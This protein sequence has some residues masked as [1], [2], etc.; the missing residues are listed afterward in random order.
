MTFVKMA[1]RQATAVTFVLFCGMLLT[2]TLLKNRLRLGYMW[3]TEVHN[4]RSIDLVLFDGWQRTALWYGAWM[5][6]LGNIMLFLPFGFLMM[7]LLQQRFR[8]PVLL[9]SLAGFLASLSIEIAQYVF[10]VGFTDIDDLFFNTIGSVLGAV[11]F[12]RVSP[13]TRGKFSVITLII[14]VAVVVAML[15]SMM[16]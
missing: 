1:T 10:A 2:I 13:N 16:F 9:A 11:A 5:D 15:V 8:Y 3:S 12:G 4:Q 7:G 14:A 6:S